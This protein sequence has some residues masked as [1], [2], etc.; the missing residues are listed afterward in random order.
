MGRKPLF[1][2][3]FKLNDEKVYLALSNLNKNYVDVAKQLENLVEEY[4]RELED[5]KFT[6]KDMMLNIDKA[7]SY[8]RKNGVNWAYNIFKGRIDRGSIPYI[9]GDDGEKYILKS[10]LD[11]IIEF[12]NEVLSLEEAYNRI[13]QTN[14]LLSLR[15]FIGRI[16]KNKIP[17]IVK[18]RKR[19]IPKE[20]VDSLVYI[21]S[22]YVEVSTALAIYRENGINISRNTL[23][24]RLDRG[25]LPYITYGKKRLIPKDILLQSIREEKLRR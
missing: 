2:K 10:T 14:P 5:Y 18:Y 9:I 16:E 20:V 24:R 12:E 19:Y 22:N 13:K 4:E 1:D 7:Y 21:Y 25:L 15:A 23:E 6:Q 3:K 11:S 17:V 8:L